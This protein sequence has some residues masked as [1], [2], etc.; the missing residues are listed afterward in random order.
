M[1]LL[2]HVQLIT[3]IFNDVA[4]MEIHALADFGK[5][6]YKPDLKVINLQASD[7]SSF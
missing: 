4:R 2:K 6:G 3:V 5:S 1:P 7:S